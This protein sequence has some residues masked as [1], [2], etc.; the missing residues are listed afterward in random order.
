MDFKL[1]EEQQML[2]DTVNRFLEREYD[3][4]QRRKL[5]ASASGYSADHWN[6][7]A[8]MGLLAL[9]IPETD[10]GMGAGP[11]ESMIVMEA[12]GRHLVVEPFLPTAIVATA[13]LARGASPEQRE[14]LFPAIADGT[15]KVAVA[16]QEPGARFDL[17]Q[18]TTRARR[19]GSAWRLD[20][21]K[22]VVLAGDS[23]DR[24]IIPART[25]GADDATQGITLF[26]VDAQTSGLTVRGFPT[27][28]GMRT[29]EIGLADVACTTVIGAVDEGY[30]LLE[31]A[32]DRGIAAL[33]AE[34]VGAM[35]QTLDITA[36]YLKTRVQFGQPLARFQ[37]IQ[38]RIA[39]I[40][41]ALEQSRAV[42]LLAA[43]DMDN[44]DRDQ[45]R[46][47]V[48]TAKSIVGRCGRQIGEAAIQLHGGMGMSDEMPVGLYFK[49]LRCIDMTWGNSDHQLEQYVQL[50][51]TA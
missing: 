46:R 3:L 23:A 34:A 40:F 20:G 10:G 18:V 17:W 48:A 47:S 19:D 2:A 8:E 42:A 14:E 43:A 16:T 31:W 37:V 29:A 6:M 50:M 5:L 49:R 25:S 32:V 11:V 15:L 22:A 27:I 24:I 33:C 26:L 35:E 28:D 4:L 44:P 13:V 9:N 1:N 36:E 39:E 30:P 12:F 41:A 38:H 51:L 45:R 7:M 21:R